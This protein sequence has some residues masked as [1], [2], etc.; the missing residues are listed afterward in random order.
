MLP[1]ATFEASEHDQIPSAMGMLNQGVDFVMMPGDGL[2]GGPSCGLLVGPTDE[3]EWIRNSTAWPTLRASDAVQGMM[4]VA[5]E[6]AAT[7]PDE[8]P[9]RALLS[10]GEENLR[11]RAERM[12]TRLTAVESI[13]TC[14][15][16][17][18][19]ASLTHSGR[20][21]FPSRQLQ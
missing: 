16:T 19:D 10:T 14:Q 3:I 2:A 8:L 1:V 7:S 9:V 5:L 11:G 6:K 15:I 13:R 18:E 21:R 4:V 20:W 12:A 17:A